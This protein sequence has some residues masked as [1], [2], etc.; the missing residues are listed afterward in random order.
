MGVESEALAR[1]ERKRPAPRL[2]P[3]WLVG[4]FQDALRRVSL[5]KRPRRSPS[6]PVQAV[7]IAR[8][9]PFKVMRFASVVEAAET[10]TVTV[11]HEGKASGPSHLAACQSLP[12]PRAEKGIAVTV[13]IKQRAAEA[14]RR[15]GAP[16]T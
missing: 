15:H 12:R 2:I 9:I 11:G 16:R 13:K 14:R 10:D 7:R 6:Y 8:K 5:A 1:G 3:L 4:D